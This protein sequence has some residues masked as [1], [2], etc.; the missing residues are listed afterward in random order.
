[1]EEAHAD[2]AAYFQMRGIDLAGDGR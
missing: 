2:L 1:M